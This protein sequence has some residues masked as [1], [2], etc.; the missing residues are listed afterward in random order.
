MVRRAPRAPIGSDVAVIGNVNVDLIV[1]DVRELPPPGEE[2]TVEVADI[3]SGGAASN[4]SLTLAS[5][6]V[7]SSVVGTVGDDRLGARLIEDLADAGI[8]VSQIRTAPAS[9]TGISI[10]FE[11]PGRDRSFLTFL[12]SLADLDASQISDRVTQTRFVLVTGYFLLPAL[13]QDLPAVVARVHAAGGTVL[14][15]TG[16]DPGGWSTQTRSAIS[17]L[18]P[19]VDI[20]LPNEREATALTGE[21]DPEIAARRL[22]DTSGSWVVVKQGSDGCSAVGPGGAE[23]RCEATPVDVV[24]TV[25]AGDAFNAGFIAALMEGGTPVDA[26]RLATD[27]ASTFVSRPSGDRYPTRDDLAKGPR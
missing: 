14:L 3:R 18:L 16:A 23:G 26:L 1:R 10:A 15:D 12:G 8:D 13:A 7:A 9:R 6:G 25:G 11:A 20:F 27:V 22:R 19:S 5:L 2:W 24:D 21:P 17:E 4:T